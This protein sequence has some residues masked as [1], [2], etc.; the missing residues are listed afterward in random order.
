MILLVLVF[1]VGLTGVLTGVG[2]TIAARLDGA[3]AL[4]NWERAL[5]G[6]LVGTLALYYGVMAIGPWRLD[7]VS[8]GGLGLL[9]VLLA[10]PGWRAMPWAAFRQSLARLAGDGQTDWRRMTLLVTLAAVV[11]ASFLQGLA[12]PNDYDS[13]NYHLPI[14]RLDLERGFIAPAYHYQIPHVFFPHLTTNLVRFSWALVGMDGVQPAVGTLGLAAIAA[15]IL[16]GRCIGLGRIESLFAG[17]I[18]VATRVVVWEIGTV[19]TDLPLAATS[20]A[21]LIVFLA[22]WRAPRPGLLVLFGLLLGAGYGIKLQ[23]GMVAL[24]FGL[25]LIVAALKRKAPLAQLALAPLVS[26]LVLVP[27][28]IENAHATGNP[29]FPLLNERLIADGKPMFE[30]V[31]LFYG[32]GRG[33]A[34]LLIAP[35]GIS[36][37]PMQHY[38]G[39]I[40]GAPVLLALAPL[41]ILGRDRL[42]QAGILLGW[43]ALYYVSWFYVQSQQARFLLPALPL[44]AGLAALGGSSLLRATAPFAALRNA[45][46]AL[47]GLL[48]V[49]QALFVGIYATIRLPPALGL[50]TPLAYHE[51]TPTLNGAFYRTC[52]FVSER[53]RPSESYLSF[54]GPH[55]PY[56]PQR[57]AILRRF[58]D[59]NPYWFTNRPTPKIDFTAFVERME[60]AR[61][62]FVITPIASENRRNDTGRPILI[63]ANLE[64]ARFGPFVGPVL[65]GL[66]PLARE[67]YSAVYD[68]GQV[69]D[70]LKAWRDSGQALPAPR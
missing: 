13:L 32:T 2:W 44:I 24:A 56:C 11:G 5:C 10:V 8:M 52:Q 16:L 57:G 4:S 51:R 68:G 42:A 3:K 22:W 37:F 40:L 60:Q 33:L 63:P 45:G 30:G 66:E 65:E 27:H 39:M 41:A 50:M 17:L 58:E 61:I 6:Y 49:N 64:A 14:P 36:V 34:D 15:T 23:G 18:F 62:R 28:L 9:L 67:P 38:D 55:S 19:E 46:L 43:L 29:L 35:W 31:A 47:F 26:I 1:V 21:A 20:A 12:P 7:R 54:L 48:F 53:L 59:E 70:R 69:L 25:P